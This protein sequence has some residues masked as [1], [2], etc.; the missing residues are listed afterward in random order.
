MSAPPP[1]SFL[2]AVMIARRSG[3]GFI[4]HPKLVRICVVH[5]IGHGFARFGRGKADRERRVYGVSGLALVEF[6][7]D[8]IDEQQSVLRVSSI[9]GTLAV[10]IFRLLLAFV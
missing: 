1:V 3:F 5:R 2:S 4:I 7:R 8:Q 9:S 10:G 6:G